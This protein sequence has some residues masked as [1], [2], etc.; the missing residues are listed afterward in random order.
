MVTMSQS[1]SDSR[2]S[3]GK[4]AIVFARTPIRSSIMTV[5]PHWIDYNG[6][7]NVAWYHVLFGRAIDDLYGL[8]GI[9]EEYLAR[10]HRSMFALEAHISYLREIKAGDRVVAD[11]QI[12]D[13]DAKRIHFFQTLSHADNGF[14]SATSETMQLH[15]DMARRRATPFPAEPL[16]RI[17][18]CADAQ[19]DL[20]RPEH[21]GRRI[22]M[23]RPP[24]K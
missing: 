15:V 4:P 16:A 5:E 7:L 20:P 19:A 12:L 22:G 24:G 17:T 23:R 11:S 13:Y 3:G 14:V 2:A 8:R 18:A 1:M 21:A 6:H 10:T 9:G